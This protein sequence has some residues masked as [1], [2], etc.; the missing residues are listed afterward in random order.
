MDRKFFKRLR[1]VVLGIFFVHLSFLFLGLEKEVDAKPSRIVSMNLCSDQL[2]LR[3]AD[4]SRIAAV[5]R[6]S[7]IPDISTVVDLAQGLNTISGTLEEVLTL[8]PDI[9]ITGKYDSQKINILKKLGINVVSIGIAKSFDDLKK[10]IREIA[11]VL[12]EE[13]K[14]KALIKDIDDRLAKIKAQKHGAINGVFYRTGGVGF[15][16][17]PLVSPIQT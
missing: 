10:N 1:Y 15:L 5:T 11:A 13:E 8:D 3:L 9:V 6:S 17:D 12:E 7:L 4:R 14:G 2:V 16:E